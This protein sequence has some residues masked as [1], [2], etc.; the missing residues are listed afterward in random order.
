M[1]ILRSMYQE[2]RPGATNRNTPSKAAKLS[3]TCV[4]T[5][6]ILSLTSLV[7]SSCCFERPS[8]ADPVSASFSRAASRALTLFVLFCGK[9]E[10]H[11]TTGAIYL[12]LLLHGTH[13]KRVDISFLAT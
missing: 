11:R 6:D 3:C 2:T 10:K 13:G 8:A 12:L 9:R 1:F 7:I 5:G 4:H